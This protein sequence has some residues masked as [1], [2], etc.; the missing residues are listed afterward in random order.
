MPKK[1]IRT[2]KDEVKDVARD[3]KDNT[4]TAYDIKKRDIEDNVI[5]KSVLTL[6]TPEEIA[7]SQRIGLV[8]G[9]TVLLAII[10]LV[11]WSLL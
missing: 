4:V 10:A 5:P 3:I 11:V 8:I 1:F 7:R 2:I 9:F 6:L